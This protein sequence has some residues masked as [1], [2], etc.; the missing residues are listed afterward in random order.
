MCSIIFTNK[1]IDNLDDVNYYQ[2]FRGPDKTSVVKDTEN[3]FSYVHNLLSITGEFRE[4]PFVK[5]DVLCIFNGEIYNYK[6]YG[7]YQSDGDCIL[8][9]Y[10]EY[11]DNFT[12]KLDGEFAILLVDYNKNKMIVSTDVF[13]T[14]PLWISFDGGIGVASYHSALSRLG[15]YDI[16]KVKANC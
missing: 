12:S 11:G 6:Q 3:G 14:K 9:L 5:D 10:F 7:D 4:Q 2:K 13:A 16:K 15:F 1:N 8:D